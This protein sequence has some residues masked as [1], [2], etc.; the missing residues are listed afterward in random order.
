M[1]WK[2]LEA[3]KRIVVNLFNKN[4]EYCTVKI[5]GKNEVETIR[6]IKKN[7]GEFV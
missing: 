1:K 5:W 7:C 6:G 2:P 3:L 4:N